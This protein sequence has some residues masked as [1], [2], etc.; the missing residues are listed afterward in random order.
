[1]TF[2]SRPN[3]TSFPKLLFISQHPIPMTFTSRP[4]SISYLQLQIPHSQHSKPKYP[5][6]FHLVSSSH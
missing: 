1:M 2:P 3:Y 5:T 4:N 6:P